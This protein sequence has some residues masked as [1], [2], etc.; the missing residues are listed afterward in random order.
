MDFADHN[1]Q[2]VAPPFSNVGWHQSG[3]VIGRQTVSIT[4]DRHQFVDAPAPVN[5]ELRYH[6]GKK[7]VSEMHANAFGKTILVDVHA[8]DPNHM[9]TVQI[10][11]HGTFELR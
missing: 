4:V 11:V 6:D 2:G 5:V 9:S 7:F 3:A 10:R 1:Q 8:L